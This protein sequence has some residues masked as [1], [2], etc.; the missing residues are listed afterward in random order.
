[1]FIIYLIYPRHVQPIILII[2]FYPIALFSTKASKFAKTI[3]L[4]LIT[5]FTIFLAYLYGFKWAF[6]FGVILG[7]I[8]WSQTS[9]NSMTLI[10]CGT[11]VF[12]AY[13]GSLA[14]IWFPAPNFITGYLVAVTLKNIATFLV[15]L[16]LN[17]SPI[18]N[19]MHTFAEFLTNT[20]IAPVFLNML[21]K[22][23]IFIT[24]I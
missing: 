10:N 12:A 4:E 20:I 2:I 8:M 11:Y 9:L 1:M 15:F 17:P 14:A 21:Y 6:F 19:I 5:S 18:E 22:L 7:T 24:P 16:F 3:N 23:I 13:F